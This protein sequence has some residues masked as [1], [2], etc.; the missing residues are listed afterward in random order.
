MLEH[1]LRTE[2]GTPWTGSAGQSKPSHAKMLATIALLALAVIVTLVRDHEFWF[3]SEET[4][5]AAETVNP[6]AVSTPEPVANMVTPAAVLATPAVAAPKQ[7]VVKASASSSAVPSTPATNR[8][9]RKPLGIEVPA[10]KTVSQ[11]INSVK[12]QTVPASSASEVKGVS[13]WGPATAAAERVRMTDQAAS[14]GAAYPMLGE[15]MKVEG[16]VVMQIIIAA[17]GGVENMRV[18]SGPPILATAAREAVRNWRFKPYLQNGQPVET[19]A[20][21]TV[22]LTIRV[23][24]NS[25]QAAVGG[26][27]HKAPGL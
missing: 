24:D 25:V 14:P 16:S 9:S 19:S 10:R 4:L 22:N 27:S 17:D 23:M 20:T 8:I 15:Q 6:S 3:G 11:V 12:I 13:P 5:V 21:V 1:S 26:V 18:L 7:V 2:S